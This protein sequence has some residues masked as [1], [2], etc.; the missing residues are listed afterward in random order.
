MVN[1]DLKFVYPPS[2]E[3]MFVKMNE[4]SMQ[5]RRLLLNCG[6]TLHELMLL[7]PGSGKLAFSSLFSNLNYI[8]LDFFFIH[9]VISLI[10]SNL[11]D[12]PAH[13]NTFRH[14]SFIIPDL[15]PKIDYLFRDI[16]QCLPWDFRNW[17]IYRVRLS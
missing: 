4:H 1:W 3:G 13:P 12:L 15:K 8:F 10:I 11:Y 2:K 14:K 17:A 6:Y 5:G 7:K 16:K 9:F